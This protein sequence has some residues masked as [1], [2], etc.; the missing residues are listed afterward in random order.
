MPVP[1]NIGEGWPGLAFYPDFTL[2]EPIYQ[3]WTEQSEHFYYDP[4]WRVETDGQWIVSIF[5]SSFNNSVWKLWVI[6]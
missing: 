2:G 1:I 3:Y 4:R 6:V 5:A